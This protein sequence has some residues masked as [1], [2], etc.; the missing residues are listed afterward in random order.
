MATMTHRALD[1]SLLLVLVLAAGCADVPGHDD[2]RTSSDFS[3]SG[4]CDGL[5][6]SCYERAQSQCTSGCEFKPTCHSPFTEQCAVIRDG[7]ACDSDSSCHWSSGVCEVAV[8][9]A[10]DAYETQTACAAEPL[11]ECVWS[12]A[13]TGSSRTYCDDLHNSAACTGDLGCTWTPGS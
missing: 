10:C 2:P 8:G 9:I 13:C 11:H 7:N 1:V 4:T 6:A 5:G 12:S 3:E